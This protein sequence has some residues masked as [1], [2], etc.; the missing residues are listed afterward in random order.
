MSN[1]NTKVANLVGKLQSIMIG[2]SAES[3]WSIVVIELKLSN[4]QTLN[5]LANIDD[6]ITWISENVIDNDFKDDK[7]HFFAFF[8]DFKTNQIKH[9][10]PLSIR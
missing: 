1:T 4:Y 10:R 5:A 6:K 2:Y 7:V 9:M 3:V 8:Q